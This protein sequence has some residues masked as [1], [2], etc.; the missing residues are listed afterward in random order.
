MAVQQTGVAPIHR[1]GWI[2]RW[3][4]LLEPS[5]YWDSRSSCC[6]NR[7]SSP[8]QSSSVSTCPPWRPDRHS[9]RCVSVLLIIAESQVVYWQAY[10]SSGWSINLDFHH[11]SFYY[12]CL[13]PVKET[14]SVK[15]PVLNCQLNKESILFAHSLDPHSD[16]LPKCL[17]ERFSLAHLQGEN[18]TT[19]QSCKGG[20]RA[21]RLGDTCMTINN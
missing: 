2:S 4:T 8:S 18:L 3:L 5:L 7:I 16:G 9:R 1:E 13:L 10:R 15:K 17:A 14:Q 19:C 12:F 6:P 21:K 20:V 11:L